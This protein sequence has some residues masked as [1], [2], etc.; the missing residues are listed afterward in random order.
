M[1]N[2]EPLK[3]PYVKVQSFDFAQQH[4]RQCCEH[5]KKYLW[6]SNHIQH[7]TETVSV[8]RGSHVISRKVWGPWSEIMKNHP[9]YSNINGV[10]SNDKNAG[11]VTTKITGPHMAQSHAAPWHEQWCTQRLRVEVRVM[12]QWLV[13]VLKYFWHIKG[14]SKPWESCHEIWVR[15]TN[16]ETPQ[17]NIVKHYATMISSA[18]ATCWSGFP[19]V[20]ALLCLLQWPFINLGPSASWAISSLVVHHRLHPAPPRHQKALADA[21]DQARTHSTQPW[22]GWRKW[23]SACNWQPQVIR[24]LNGLG[25]SYSLRYNTVPIIDLGIFR[26]LWRPFKKLCRVSWRFELWYC[27]YALKGTLLHSL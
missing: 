23:R 25:L 13:E 15:L 11:R 4:H 1:S 3:S 6:A 2:H 14:T 22:T 20:K 10:T 24:W 19:N 5:A 27:L 8:P 18:G 26:W 16:R 7:P 17:M 12:Q 21:A 9:T